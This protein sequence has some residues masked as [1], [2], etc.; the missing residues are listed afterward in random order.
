LLNNLSIIPSIIIALLKDIDFS[1]NIYYKIKKYTCERGASIFYNMPFG[2]YF[3]SVINITSYYPK[4]SYTTYKS[5]CGI[6]VK[7]GENFIDYKFNMY[8]PKP[9]KIGTKILIDKTISNKEPYTITKIIKYDS[10]KRMDVI[11]ASWYG[12]YKHVS[13]EIYFDKPIDIPTFPKLWIVDSHEH[14]I[15]L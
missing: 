12:S 2:E 7:K 10:E 3:D 4:F 6:F 5:D 9:L 15:K 11:D 1:N 14:D 13:Y 8:A